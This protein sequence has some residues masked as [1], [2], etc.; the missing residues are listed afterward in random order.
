LEEKVTIWVAIDDRGYITTGST[1]NPE[2][3]EG[4]NIPNYTLTFELTW[5]EIDNLWMFYVVDGVLTR[6]TDL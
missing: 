2:W 6:R 1:T 4:D 3:I 5:D